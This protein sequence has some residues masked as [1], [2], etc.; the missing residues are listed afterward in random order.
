VERACRFC[1]HTVRPNSRFCPACGALLDANLSPGTPLR[2]GDY[3]IERSLSSGGMGNVYLARDQR[4]FDRLVVVKQML[5]YYDVADAGERAAAQERFEEEGRT[6]ASLRHPGIPEIY[7]FFSEHGRYYIVM[8]HIQGETL[9]TFVTHQNG[10][11]SVIPRRLLPMEDALRYMIEVCRIL[12][13]LHARPRPVVHGDV[14]PANLIVERQLGYVRLVDFGT[15]SVRRD[16]H[17]SGDKEDDA[18][19]YGTDGYAAPEQYQGKA[20]PKSDV[21]GLAATTYHLLTDDDPREHPFKWPKMRGLPRELALALKRALRIEPEKR[22]SVAELRQALEAIATPK[23]ALQ[24]FT[25]PG[26][27]QIRGVAALP[28]LC[29][30][31]W[32]AAR[33][34]LYKGDFQRWLR[35]INRLDLVIAADEAAETHS[36]P[37]AG[38]E[39]FL[40]AVDP[41]IARPKIVSDPQRVDLGSVAREAALIRTVTLL[42]TTRG[43]VRVNLAASEPWLEVKPS[44]AHLWAGVPVDIHVHVHAEGLPFRSQQRGNVSLEGDG[45]SPVTIPVTATVSLLR[46][47]WRLCLRTLSVAIPGAWHTAIAWVR[48]VT[49]LG[50]TISRP[51]VKRDWLLW[52]IWL[53]LSAGL[54]YLFWTVPSTLA[55][56]LDALKTSMPETIA[57]AHVVRA[58]LAILGPPSIGVAAWLGSVGAAITGGT[59]F[60][61]LRGA[62]RSFFR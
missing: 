30:E 46:E 18:E 55:F 56:V 39:A 34:F 28:T 53:L 32:D 2:N 16:G 48:W 27:Q 47:T 26:G 60:G 37:D 8:E 31:H 12:E 22:C 49:R 42:N 44:S 51:F 54:Y 4:A 13:Y 29:D 14:K 62:W 7:T 61:A 5:E 10:L 50:R 41:G 3:V 33:S 25:F 36:N 20:V 43:Y 19:A 40:H 17:S 58:L 11:G 59:L 57:T 23:R 24:S 21:F 9:K 35:D 6:L 52:L 38:L 1:G 15:A 45:I